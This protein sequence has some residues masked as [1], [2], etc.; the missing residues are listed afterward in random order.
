MLE[1]ERTYATRYNTTTARNHL[2]ERAILRNRL[3][4]QFRETTLHVQR[5]RYLDEFR[6]LPTI[7][8]TS[9]TQT[10]SNSIRH[11]IP[12][13]K[14]YVF[15][16]KISMP[17]FILSECKEFLVFTIERYDKTLYSSINF[18]LILFLNQILI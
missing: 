9:A 12:Q 18:P 8:E 11:D 4:F 2:V 14:I 10:A 3:L 5:D 7:Y 15:F 16:N 6:E 13:P 17:L 1:S